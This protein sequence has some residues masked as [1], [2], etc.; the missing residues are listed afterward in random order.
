MEIVV[1]AFLVYLFILLLLRITTRRIIRSATAADMVLVFV[2]GGFGIQAVLGDQHSVSAALLALVTVS[3]SHLLVQGLANR[4]P[5]F[6][7]LSGGSPAIVYADGR[8]NHRR[9]RDLR[10]EEADVLSEMRQKGIRRMEDVETVV[11]EHNGGISVMPKPEGGG[12]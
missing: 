7:R 1:R 9:L 11:I 6:A 5:G 10:V 3:L 4:S 8:W 2:F 12:G